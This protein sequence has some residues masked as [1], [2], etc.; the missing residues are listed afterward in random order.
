MCSLFSMLNMVGKSVPGFLPKQKLWSLA[1][2][3]SIGT[4]Q[5]ALTTVIMPRLAQ[6]LTSRKEVL[7]T[8]GNLILSF[9][10]PVAAV[11]YLD[12]GCLGNWLKLWAP[13]RCRA[14][15]DR[16]EVYFSCTRT[17]DSDCANL[18]KQFMNIH[19][20]L[21]SNSDICD[22]RRAGGQRSMA[23]CIELA[24]LRLQ[25]IWLGKFILSGLMLECTVTRR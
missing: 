2:G 18:L 1:L 23:T 6:K 12:R 19:M 11:V 24:L 10:F 21:L 4:V 17:D 14:N 9:A 5:C 8:M 7:T 15:A 16:F 3:T 22:V 25:D 13:C 20:K